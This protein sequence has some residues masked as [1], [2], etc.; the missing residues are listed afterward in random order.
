VSDPGI[1]TRKAPPEMRLPVPL[2]VRA[3]S[4]VLGVCTFALGFL[5]LTEITPNRSAALEAVSVVAQI[6]APLAWALMTAG[7]WVV[8]ATC[9]SQARASAHAIAAVTHGVH[10][11]ALA[12]TFV[13]AY[14]LQPAPGVITAVFAVI[15]H[16]GGSLDYWKR[17]WR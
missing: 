10:L 17:G 11:T 9:L 5:Y 4:V 8:I 3:A 6:E 1:H 14:P 13:I 15:A 16:A 12:A 2:H 7:G